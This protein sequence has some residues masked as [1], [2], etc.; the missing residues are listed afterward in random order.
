MNFQTHNDID[1]D[2]FQT[3]LLDK[4]NTTYSRLVD[5]FGQPHEGSSMNDVCWDIKFPDGVVATIYNWRNKDGVSEDFNNITQ[6]NVGGFNNVRYTTLNR[7][8]E[9]IF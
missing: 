5:V 3:H 9:L 1:I 4:I 6:W 8:N 7:I 2:V